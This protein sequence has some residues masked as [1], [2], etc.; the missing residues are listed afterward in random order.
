M[1]YHGPGQLVAYP[2]V[3]ERGRADGDAGRPIASVEDAAWLFARAFAG[4]LDAGFS[5]TGAADARSI[6]DTLK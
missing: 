2:I 3:R 1:T 4:A 6:L 5:A